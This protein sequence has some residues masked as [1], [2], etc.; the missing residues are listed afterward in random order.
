[1]IGEVKTNGVS[2]FISPFEFMLITL[3]ASFDFGLNNE[4]FSSWRWSLTSTKPNTGEIA[5]W[6]LSY[7]LS[8]PNSSL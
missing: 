8:L 1:L 5:G 6:V 4:D 7:F 3:S 2:S